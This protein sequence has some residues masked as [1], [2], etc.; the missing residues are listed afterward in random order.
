MVWPMG[1]TWPGAAVMP[2]RMPAAGASTSMVTLS[3]STSRMG[4]PLA[5]AAPSAT[6]QRPTTPVSWAI[7][8]LGMM[9]AVGMGGFLD[10]VVGQLA[11]GGDDVFDLRDGGALE[12][13]IVGDGHVGAAQTDDGRLQIGEG[14]AL[15]DHG[16]D[17]TAEAA[18]EGGLMDDDE[19]AGFFDGGDDG[20]GVVGFEGA[21]VDDFELYRVRG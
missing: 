8:N 11:G 1:M 5:T 16:G 13:A 19:P 4:S 17:F 9:T 12:V 2:R 21:E 10:L 14:L 7:S 6:S 18:D 15:G 20:R 3:V